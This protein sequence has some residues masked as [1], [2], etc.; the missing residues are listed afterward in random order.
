MCD[1]ET[2]QKPSRICPSLHDLA[3]ALLALKHWLQL[4]SYIFSTA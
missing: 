1:E 3:N 4:I 2:T